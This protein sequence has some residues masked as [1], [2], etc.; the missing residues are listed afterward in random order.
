MQS[1]LLQT[2]SCFYPLYFY[3]P[4]NVMRFFF[5]LQLYCNFHLRYQAD[6]S[7]EMRHPCVSL[8]FCSLRACVSVSNN[9][10]CIL[11]HTW[12]HH[13]KQGIILNKGNTDV[14]VNNSNQEREVRSKCI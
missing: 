3:S 7:R 12:K 1:L 13:T 8:S 2:T 10:K 4:R 6:C 9:Q 14:L 5:K 11:V